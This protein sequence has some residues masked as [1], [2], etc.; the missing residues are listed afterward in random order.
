MWMF[1]KDG[2]RI[3]CPA[4]VYMCRDEGRWVDE[5]V[6]P[7]S[8]NP[9]MTLNMTQ[10]STASASTRA[11]SGRKKSTA[12]DKKVENKAVEVDQT[13]K[14]EEEEEEAFGKDENK[15]DDEGGMTEDIAMFDKLIGDNSRSAVSSEQRRSLKMKLSSSTGRRSKDGE[16][17]EADMPSSSQVEQAISWSDPREVFLQ[18][19]LSEL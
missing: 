3:V 6:F 15:D 10:T 9:K 19:I 5:E 17:D 18:S 13:L 14:E 1:L 7:H 2:K 16:A 4:W 8:Y 11:R 12:A